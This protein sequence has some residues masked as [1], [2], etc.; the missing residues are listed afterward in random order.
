M[1]SDFQDHEDITS[2]AAAGDNDEVAA[3]LSMDNR[4]TRAVSKDGWT[5]L[6]LAAHFGHAAVV[7]T[8]LAN[9]AD[10]RARSANEM[11]NQPL[12]AAAAGRQVEA[13]RLLLDAGADPNATQAA[14]FVPLHSAA[15]NG[16]RA[17][18]ELLLARGADANARTEDGRTALALAE[19]AGRSDVAELLRRHGAV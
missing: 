16:D 4:L 19:A 6:H 8:L 17:L 7:E 12:H 5:P 15:Q 18:V 13:A 9:N 14:G 3:I 10:V 2:A 11:H 1:S